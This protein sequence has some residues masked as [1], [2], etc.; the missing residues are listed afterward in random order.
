MNMKYELPLN[1]EVERLRKK[2]IEI[3]SN[4]GF[5]S[6]ESVEVSQ[7]LDLLLNKMQME[8]QV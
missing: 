5:A 1:D 6:Q 4:Q 8:H 2:M 7:E 3:A